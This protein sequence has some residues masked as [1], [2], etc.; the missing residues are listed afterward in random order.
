MKVSG[1]TTEFPTWGSGKGTENLGEFDFAGQ[2]DLITEFIQDWRNRLLEDT[3]KTL[4]LPIP[5]RKEKWPH[6]KLTQTCLWVSRSLQQRCGLGVT[7]CRV[8]GTEPS[9]ACTGPLEG[10]P[11]PP[12]SLVSGPTTGRKHSPALQQKI[13]SKMYWAWLTHQN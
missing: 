3:G 9:T 13:D 5:R 12:P 4:C 2:W 7:C 10:G 6:K 8:G 1:L 11:L